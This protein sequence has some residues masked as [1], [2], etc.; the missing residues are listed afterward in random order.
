MNCFC[1]NYHLE[2]K[3][4]TSI[5]FSKDQKQREKT[6]GLLDFLQE[7]LK[8]NFQAEMKDIRK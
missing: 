4:K 7:M 6:V 1:P 2:L 8:G 3:D 5:L